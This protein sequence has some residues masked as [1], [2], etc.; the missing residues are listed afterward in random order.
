MGY[1]NVYAYLE[2]LPEWVKRGYPAEINEIYPKSQIANVSA[3]ELK[4]MIDRNE[5]I[6]ILDIRDEDARMGGWIKGSKHIDM[7]LLDVNYT[8]V[9]KNKRVVLTDVHGKQSS[10]AIR[11]LAHKGFDPKNLFRLDGGIVSGWLKEGYPV[12]K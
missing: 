2:G 1:K 7:E 11:F 8:Q 3:K 4:D 10:K 6:F 5:D 12:E 9:P